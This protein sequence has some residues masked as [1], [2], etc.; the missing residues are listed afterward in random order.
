MFNPEILSESE[1]DIKNLSTSFCSYCCCYF[2]RNF[3][4][5]FDRFMFC[6]HLHGVVDKN[7]VKSKAFA[8]LHQ[9]LNDNAI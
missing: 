6:L 9:N 2:D 8:P 5:S 7:N 3:E 1:N 4:F